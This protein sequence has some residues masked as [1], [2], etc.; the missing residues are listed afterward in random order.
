MK[1]ISLS[2]LGLAALLALNSSS[3]RASQ[4]GI[5][6]VCYAC[7]NNGDVAV[8]AALA[9][10]PGVASDGILFDF[11]N[12]SAFA[13]TGGIF[14]VSGTSP[15]DSFAL[16][17]I[18]AHT[19]FILIPGVTS[20]GNTHPSGG[21]FA[22]AGVMD[23]S[24]GSGGITDSSVFKF[25]GI[26][27][28]LAVTSITDGTSTAIAGTFTPADPGLFL[29][30]RAPTGGS[31]SFVGDGPNGDGGCTNCYF[32]AVATLD[33]PN[34]TGVPEPQGGLLMLTGLGLVIG[35]SIVGRRAAR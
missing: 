35:A 2:F 14:S 10:N 13:I 18:P 7:Q 25:T 9:A 19:E 26:S 12:T 27:N 23:T 4:I 32:S 31:T 6:T 34:V 30:W 3:I 8:D 28:G 20:D 24:D 16:P 5:V 15:A 1:P 21:L 33:T 22:L 17:T 11:D 29:P